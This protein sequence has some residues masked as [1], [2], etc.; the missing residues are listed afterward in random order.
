[1]VR[2]DHIASDRRIL[3]VGPLRGDLPIEILVRIW[4]EVSRGVAR[5]RRTLKHYILNAGLVNSLVYEAILIKP[6]MQKYRRGAE[7]MQQR[8]RGWQALRNPPWTAR[9][10]RVWQRRHNNERIMRADYV[11]TPYTSYD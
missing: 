9:E 4:R 10:A 2:V 5:V 11:G 1:M 7:L 6:G 3:A 8:R